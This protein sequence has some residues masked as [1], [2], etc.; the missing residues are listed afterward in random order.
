MTLERLSSPVNNPC[1]FNNQCS[2]WLPRCNMTEFRLPARACTACHLHST[3]RATWH[4]TR[5][6][7]WLSLTTENIAGF[8]KQGRV[9]EESMRKWKQET[10]WEITKK[11]IWKKCSNKKEAINKSSRK[12]TERN[13]GQKW[14]EG[15]KRWSI[16]IKQRKSRTERKKKPRKEENYPEP[17][18]C[19]K[20]KHAVSCLRKR[21]PNVSINVHDSD[22]PRLS[23]CG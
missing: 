8:W 23:E 6:A 19:H 1:M 12:R 16:K 21:Q 14:K 11:E 7:T 9:K 20:D 18:F 15:M 3:R 22:T 2:D 4:S 17:R 13:K 10:E 5:R